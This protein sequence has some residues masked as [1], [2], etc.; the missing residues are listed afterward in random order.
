[1][2]H[3]RENTFLFRSS[4]QPPRLCHR[5]LKGA[6]SAQKAL[7]S[8]RALLPELQRIEDTVRCATLCPGHRQEQLTQTLIVRLLKTRLI[9]IVQKLEGPRP[10]LAG[11]GG[12]ETCEHG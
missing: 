12:F 8:P 6:M 5:P 9:S 7:E 1:M 4:P 2:T 3:R 10:P 11:P